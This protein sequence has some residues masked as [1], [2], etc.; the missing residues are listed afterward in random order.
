MTT[1]RSGDGALGPTTSTPGGVRRRLLRS[2]LAV[3]LVGLVI[4]LVGLGSSLW[5]RSNTLRLAT[6]RGP[7]AQGSIRAL[8]GV[9]QS[10][11]GL[12]AWVL[13]GNPDSKRERADAWRDEIDP[14]VADLQR[15]SAEW[16]NPDNRERLHRL[17]AV[18]E[19]LRT[20]QWW[21]EDVAQTPGNRPA[22]VAY[23]DNLRPIAHLVTG[24]ITAL[25]A[26]E[27]QT[28][29]DG[30]RARLTAMAELRHAFT[31]STTAI[32]N[33]LH[34]G[35]PDDERRFRTT[36]ERALAALTELRGHRVDLTADQRAVLAWL[37]A[38]VVAWTPLAEEAIEKR[39]HPR[40]DRARYWLTTEAL[41]RARAATTLLEAISAEQRALIQDDAALVSSLD[42]AIVG[43][44]LL[45]IAI[46]VVAAWVVSQRTADRLT[47]P[48]AALAG[49]TAELAAGRLTG[50]IP[51][52]TDDELG[53]RTRS[54]NTVRASLD[55]PARDP[56]HQTSQPR[57]ANEAADAIDR[58]KSDA[59]ATM[60]HEIRI[61]LNAIIGITERLLDTTP[62]EIQ[63]AY[64][65]IVRRAG[66]SL[67]ASVNNVLDSSTEA[68]PVELDPATW[69]E[70]LTRPTRE[71]QLEL[72]YSNDP[73]R[74]DTAGAGALNWTQA[75]ATVSGDR[76]L[77]KKVIAAHLEACPGLRDQLRTA[78]VQGDA[79]VVRR[80]ADTIKSGLRC[81]GEPR[82]VALAYRLEAAGRRGWLASAAEQ[83]VVLEEELERVEPELRAFLA[84]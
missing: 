9:R 39:K 22:Q 26:L 28:P 79:T 80:A 72:R 70:S 81:F 59:V 57:L 12:R 54:F 49:A 45:L 40:A 18:L 68:G 69:S 19:E 74:A 77:L 67:L 71:E 65:E 6:L 46:V 48:I 75:L 82:A 41:P 3:G 10:L 1:A 37:A 44:A 55:T 20:W 42:N 34:T 35:D 17:T 78:I 58:T 36:G 63:R 29:D 14:G 8:A 2:H 30:D 31:L 13:L 56:H 53:E 38:D 23:M 21:I 11:A 50:D 47:R 43:V 66:D 16:T 4:L 61:P 84:T 60:S 62:S 51:V 7:T 15:L 73:V 76:S 33:F 52:T 32:A 64:L 24:G 5:L 27:Q 83:C 25:L